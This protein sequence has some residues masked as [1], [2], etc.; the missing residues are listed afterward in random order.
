VMTMRIVP[1]IPIQV[2]DTIIHIGTQTN[3]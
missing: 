2:V 1:V 3:I